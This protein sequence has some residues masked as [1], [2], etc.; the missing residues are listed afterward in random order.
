MAVCATCRDA[1]AVH[2]CQQAAKPLVQCDADVCGSCVVCPDHDAECGAGDACTSPGMPC[3]Q[4]CDLCDHTP[5]C[6]CVDTCPSCD[7]KRERLLHMDPTPEC[8]VCGDFL[9]PFANLRR[10]PICN[11]CPNSRRRHF[12]CRFHTP[13]QVVCLLACSTGSVSDYQ[14]RAAVWAL[15]RHPPRLRLRLPF[16]IAHTLAELI[17][18]VACFA[19][20]RN[21]RRRRLLARIL[22]GTWRHGARSCLVPYC[23]QPRACP[24]H[25]RVPCSHKSKCN[26]PAARS[27][28]YCGAPLCLKHPQCRRPWCTTVF[29]PHAQAVL[30]KRKYRTASLLL[31]VTEPPAPGAASSPQTRASGPSS[32]TQVLTSGDAASIPDAETLCSSSDRISSTASE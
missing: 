29:K 26:L 11:L 31:W 19:S 5:L 27:C 15:V 30:Q 1:P 17:G 4:R 2:K 14:W 22:R 16:G 13:P 12:D 24:N 25:R 3:L 20:L 10:Y 9:P 32:P 23:P 7:A 6:G 18:V 28:V 8:C 21:P